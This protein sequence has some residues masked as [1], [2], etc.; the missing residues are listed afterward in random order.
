[1]L[2]HLWNKYR[3][4]GAYKAKAIQQNHQHA[5]ITSSSGGIEEVKVMRMFAVIQKNK[6]E[7]ESRET[8]K[9]RSH[10]QRP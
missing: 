5:H 8:R 1:M 9:K 10:Q 3:P 6:H 2:R 7:V 4:S